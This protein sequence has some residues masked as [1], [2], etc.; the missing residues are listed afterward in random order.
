MNKSQANLITVEKAK[1]KWKPL[2]HRM[3]SKLMAM[4]DE[5]AIE[6]KRLLNQAT[7]KD[8]RENN[9]I[10]AITDDIFDDVCVSAPDLKPTAPG[11]P[12]RYVTGIL[13]YKKERLELHFLDEEAHFVDRLIKLFQTQLEEKMCGLIDLHFTK[14]NAM[15]DNFSKLMRDHAPVDFSVDPRGE[16]IRVELEKHIPYIEEKTLALH[17]LLP[18]DLSQ[19]QESMLASEDSFDDSNGQSQDLG[20]FIEKVSKKKRAI[21]DGSPNTNRREAEPKVKRI[22]YET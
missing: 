7:L 6:E 16:A 1:L 20:Y 5:M 8:E 4:M 15:F 12:K 13:K 19:D 10:A 22:K 9:I 18:V 3:Q 11:K 17:D 21:G 14:M 2:Q